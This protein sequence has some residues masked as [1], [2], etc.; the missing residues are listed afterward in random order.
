[1]SQVPPPL[2]LHADKSKGERLVKKMELVRGRGVLAAAVMAF[3]IAGNFTA[4]AA[5]TVPDPE[6][7]VAQPV[8]VAQPAAGQAASSNVPPNL[9]QFAVPCVSKI[10]ERIFCA[11][12][13]SA[14]VVLARSSGESACLLGKTWGYDDS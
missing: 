11:A 10:G 2:P 6:P 1:M 9:Q 3:M 4:M 12:D 5:K 14:G 7:Q 8:P 13:T